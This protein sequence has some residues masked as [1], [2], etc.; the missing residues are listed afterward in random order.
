MATK[1]QTKTKAKRVSKRE[2]IGWMNSWCLE[3]YCV[4]YRPDGTCAASVECLCRQQKESIIALIKSG[5]KG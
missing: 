5:R 2:M 3:S 4:S 1:D